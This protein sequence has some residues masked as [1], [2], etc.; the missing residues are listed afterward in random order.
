MKA[1]FVRQILTFEASL[2]VGSHVRIKW[3]AGHGKY[4]GVGI[5][6]KIERLRFR[7][8]LM[9]AVSLRDSTARFP[10]GHEVCVPRF[11]YNQFMWDAVNRVEPL[12]F[13]Y[14]QDKEPASANCE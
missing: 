5:V 8:K 13:G 7:V 12:P 1:E 14:D 9:R 6:S 4:I 2:K 3:L 10:V 11:R